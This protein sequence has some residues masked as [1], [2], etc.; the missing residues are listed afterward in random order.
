MN[1]CPYCGMT[2]H[3]G[4]CW[5]VKSI[6]Y[7][8]NGAVKRVELNDGTTVASAVPFAGLPEIHQPK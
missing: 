1:P 8:P 7:F 2:G 3:T 6:E 5:R 4:T